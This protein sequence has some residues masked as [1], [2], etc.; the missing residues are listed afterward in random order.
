MRK[1]D[2]TKEYYLGNLSE[3]QRGILKINLHN[4]KIY[5]SIAI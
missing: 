2:E 3:E 4:S 5:H 1:L